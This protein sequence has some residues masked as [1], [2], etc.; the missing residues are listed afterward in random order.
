MA[1]HDSSGD[2]GSDNKEDFHTLNIGIPTHAMVSIAGSNGTT[3]DFSAEAPEV[4]GNSV[5][6]TQTSDSKLYLNYS[7]IVTSGKTNTISAKVSVITSYS[8]HYTKLYDQLLTHPQQMARFQT[9]AKAQSHG[10][11]YPL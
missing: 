2:S 5:T 8:I 1:S 9:L 4:A 11:V 6:F 10:T 3:V 7:S